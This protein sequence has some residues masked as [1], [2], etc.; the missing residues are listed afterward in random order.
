M[1]V[2]PTLPN[3][4]VLFCDD[5]RQEVTGKTIF[6]G[7]YQ[8]EMIFHASPPIT[9]AIL[10]ASIWYRFS[11][12][13]VPPRVEFRIVFEN[14]AGERTVLYTNVADLTAPAEVPPPPTDPNIQ[15]Y[16]EVHHVARMAQIV[17]PEAGLIRARVYVGDDEVRLGTLE[18]SFVSPADVG[19]DVAS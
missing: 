12:A 13:D 4:F 16:M 1:I 11:P 17:I 2:N 14:K 3:G 9:I 10:A 5:V 18:A 8:H 7:A 6:V 15:P 19:P